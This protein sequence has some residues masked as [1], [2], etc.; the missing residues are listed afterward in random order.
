MHW[1]IAT[2]ACET[3]VSPRELIDLEPRMLWTM[4]RYLV[5]KNQAQA[6]ANRGKRRR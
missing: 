1:L 2:I 3:G 6:K 4:S 5:A